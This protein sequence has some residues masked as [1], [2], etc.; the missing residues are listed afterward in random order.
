MKSEKY[1]S[2]GNVQT[3][4][5]LFKDRQTQTNGNFHQIFPYSPSNFSIFYEFNLLLQSMKQFLQL[6]FLNDVILNTYAQYNAEMF[7]KMH[8]FAYTLY[9]L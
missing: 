4:E 3:E 5:Q 2:E 8:M 7:K 1:L 6:F 9:S